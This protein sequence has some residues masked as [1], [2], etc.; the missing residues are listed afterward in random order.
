MSPVRSRSAPADRSA[1]FATIGAA[2]A[3]LLA[4]MPI[5]SGLWEDEAATFWVVKD[6][7]PEAALRSWT[8]SGQSVLYYATAWLGRHLAPFLGLEISLRLPSLVAMAAAAW[9]LYL[10]GRRLAGPAV[11]AVAVLAFLCLPEVAFAAIDARPYALALA[12]LLASTLF[13]IRW[14]DGGR[15]RDAALYVA[16]AALVVYAHYLF[17]LALLPHAVYAAR[18]S[19]ALAGLWT[20]VGALCLPLAGQVLY[21]YRTRH[22]HSFAQSPAVESYFMAIV[23]PALAGA[24]FLAVILRRPK[25]DVP[26]LPWSFLFAWL[27]VPTTLV[28][29]LSLFTEVKL[30]VPRYLLGCAPAAALLAAWAIVRCSAVRAAR[31]VLLVALALHIWKQ[32]PTHGGEEW[33][34]AM[35]ALAAEAKPGDKLLIA[36]GFI[37]GSGAA[38]QDPLLR[39][40]LFAPQIA[41][42]VPA[43]TGLPF[44]FDAAFI[45]GDLAAYRRVFLVTRRTTLPDY[46]TG[47]K[48]E[49]YVEGQL[50][51][52]HARELC[53]PGAISVVAFER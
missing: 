45:P 27:M 28:F 22:T 12:L 13:L 48:Y 32:G 17:A 18:R 20:A 31:A 6:G 36:T 44:R 25:P 46:A 51:G 11:G 29:L 47:I 33:R 35:R 1:A 9:L 34:G 53:E 14:V 4:A 16:T 7:L 50:P 26:S 19:R 15:A 49:H 38:M 40:V 10:V 3:F 52:W 39:D 43:F 30:F 8:W 21:F 23:P 24:V 2:C 42:P 37:E 5:R 41:Y